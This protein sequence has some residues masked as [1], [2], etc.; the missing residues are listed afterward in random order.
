M[1]C[2]ELSARGSNLDAWCRQI[3]LAVGPVKWV[4]WLDPVWE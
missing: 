2:L 4:M 1:E 3:S